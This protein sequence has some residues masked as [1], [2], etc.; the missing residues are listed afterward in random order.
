MEAEVKILNNPEEVAREAAEQ[1][2]GLA[3]NALRKKGCFTVALSGGSTPKTFYAL[4]AEESGFREKIP[5]EKIHFFWSDERHVPP[6]HPDSNFLMARATLLSKVPVPLRN[7][8]RIPSEKPDAMRAADDYEKTL[9]AFFDAKEG[10]I[11]TLDLVLLGLGTD[12]HTASLF[13]G[14]PGLAE[15]KS[16]IM[17]N[18]VPKF[19]SYRITMTFPIINQAAFILVLVT[20]EDKA[21]IL[22][23]VL[24]G[25]PS[26]PGYPAQRVHPANGKCLWIVDRA[27]ARL[28]ERHQGDADKHG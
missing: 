7:V 2:A 5:W 8:H 13:P 26:E 22:R 3:Q 9:R 24:E 18:W 10:E 19:N 1:F 17:A 15:R 21:E 28:L 27:A 14:S 25:A 23:A 20:G 12:G 4:L 6:D 11:P 16:L